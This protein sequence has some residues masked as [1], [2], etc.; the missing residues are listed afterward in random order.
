MLCGVQGRLF[1]VQSL[2]P[3]STTELHGDD[4][5]R[6]LDVGL[7]WHVDG[8]FDLLLLDDVPLLR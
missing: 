8:N 1:K 2:S 5:V 3:G 4:A 6:L 7:S